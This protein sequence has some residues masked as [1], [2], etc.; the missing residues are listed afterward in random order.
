MKKNRLAPKWDLHYGEDYIHKGKP[1]LGP[2]HNSNAKAKY[3]LCT[4]KKT[5][6][7]AN[8]RQ[9]GPGH[10]TT[11]RCCSDAVKPGQ[12][13]CKPNTGMKVSSPYYTGWRE[14]QTTPREVL[15][16]H[17]G[18]QRQKQ[19]NFGFVGIWKS[20]PVCLKIHEVL[21]ICCSLLIYVVND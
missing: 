10:Q 17:L 12:W 16:R 6:A 1:T 15:G 19:R 13:L 8:A 20:K 3:G 14:M 11:V 21:P 18:R 4:W 7:K 5:S 9:V 2:V